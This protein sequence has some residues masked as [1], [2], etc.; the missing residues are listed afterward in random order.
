MDIDATYRQPPQQVQDALERIL[1]TF[2]DM[3][4]ED[5]QYRIHHQPNS[6]HTGHLFVSLVDV[7]RWLEGKEIYPM[8]FV[9][10]DHSEGEA[11][12]LMEETLCP[13]K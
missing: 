6:C 1:S 13:Q 12:N 5:F 7:A 11:I 8:D 3:V 9:I 10:A 4:L 2:W